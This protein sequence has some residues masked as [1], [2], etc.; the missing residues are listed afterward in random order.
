MNKHR[1]WRTIAVA[2][3]LFL[4]L[5]P[6]MA[7]SAQWTFLVYMD[8][9]NN[10]ERYVTRDFEREIVILYEWHRGEYHDAHGIG[11]FWPRLP[12]DLDEPSSPE[13]DFDYY[14]SSLVFSQ[15]TRWDEF[16]DAYVVR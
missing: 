6:A 3:T 13:N 7:V 1:V 9:D 16:L 5:A 10:L 4:L 14:R 11:L 2:V 15:E 8:G 12:A